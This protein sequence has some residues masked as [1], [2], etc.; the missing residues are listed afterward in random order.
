MLIV[1]IMILI[2]LCQ[3]PSLIAV[4]KKCP[5]WV[6][7]ANK[8]EPFLRII[9]DVKEYGIILRSKYRIVDARYENGYIYA[10]IIRGSLV[11]EEKLGKFEYVKSVK[12]IDGEI[13]I[14]Y[15]MKIDKKLNWTE[16]GLVGSACYILGI[17]TVIIILL[18]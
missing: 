14:V 17:V 3:I 1:S 16:I 18:V 6:E 12:V 7:K 13:E 9:Q 15:D 2:N 11:G 4:E 10:T 5:K 8:C